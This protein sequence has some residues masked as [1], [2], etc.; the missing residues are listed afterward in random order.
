MLT[1]DIKNHR[2]SQLDLA[3]SLRDAFQ[4]HLHTHVYPHSTIN[5]HLSILSSDGSLLAACINASTLA[6]IDAGIPMPGLLTACTIGMSGRA[7]TPVAAPQV[8]G[9][10]E[11]LDPLL[12][13]CHPE[14][15]ELPHMTIATT[16]PLPSD[17]GSG[18][19]GGGS[20]DD[21]VGNSETGGENETVSIV[22]MESGVHVSYLETMFAVGIDGCKQ[23]R[24]ILDSTIRDSATRAA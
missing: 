20:D 6:L 5:L 3:V 13:L 14:E 22:M 11:C 8:G 4:P 2:Q 17:D 1:S 9:T 15:I 7:S 19:G 18:G 23:V 21:E 24:K 16:T 10:N 12:D